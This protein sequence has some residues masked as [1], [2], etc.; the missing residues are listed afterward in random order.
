MILDE[1][2]QKSLRLRQE[3]RQL[4][5]AAQNHDGDGHDEGRLSRQS[6]TFDAASTAP[7]FWAGS[8]AAT[9]NS[10]RRNPP[11]GAALQSI[12][13]EQYVRLKRLIGPQENDYMASSQAR[14]DVHS[15]RGSNGAPIP[16]QVWPVQ[17]SAASGP[18]TTTT[19]ASIERELR[20]PSPL[21]LMATIQCKVGQCIRQ[22]LVIE[23]SFRNPKRPGRKLASLKVLGSQTLA[24]VRDAFVCMS[25]MIAVESNDQLHVRSAATNTSRFTRMPGAA[26]T[27]SRRASGQ[28]ES[29]SSLALAQSDAL[30]TSAGSM[31]NTGRQEAYFFIENVFY[32]DVRSHGAMDC[33][34]V[35]RQWMLANKESF[36]VAPVKAVLM[37]NARL[38]SLE[39][40]LG[41]SYLYMHQGSCGHTFVFDRVSLFNPHLDSS[42]AQEYPVV[43]AASAIVPLKCSVCEV[44]NASQ[45]T[46][47]DML[48]AETP[49][50][51]CDGC[52][53]EF[54][55][56]LENEPM[57]TAFRAGI[58]QTEFSVDPSVK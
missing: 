10:S 27:R 14:A 52:F 42:Q 15:D 16:A 54:H 5:H 49:T 24:D 21:P 39:L 7:A 9:A 48:T 56:G 38:D 29:G 19:A 17:R 46:F 45:A 47:D 3:A 41:Q 26:G 53:E 8:V 32:V 30:E 36:G 33:S 13:P 12:D 25:D 37:E 6:S 43:V 35:L 31:L 34:Q 50:L 22:E 18:Q 55:L 2:R 51:W 58:I 28:M 23:V 40:T 20:L 44:F 57:Y 1:I 4:A 11:A